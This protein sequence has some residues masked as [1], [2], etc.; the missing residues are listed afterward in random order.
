MYI[1]IGST[2]IYALFFI[3]GLIALNKNVLQNVVGY[4]LIFFEAIIGIYIELFSKCYSNV[5]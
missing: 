1:F 5:N 4:A 2:T 3:V